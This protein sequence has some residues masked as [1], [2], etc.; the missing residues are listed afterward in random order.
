MYALISY[1]ASQGWMFWTRLFFLMELMVEQVSS[2]IQFGLIIL[3]VG[4][5]F[6]VWFMARPTFSDCVTVRLLAVDDG[7]FPA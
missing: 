5:S 2:R 1:P 4:E 6:A 3:V 7:K